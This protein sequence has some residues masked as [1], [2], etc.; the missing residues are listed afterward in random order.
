MNRVRSILR[1][2]ITVAATFVSGTI[3]CGA[4]VSAR[5][6]IAQTP[7][8]LTLEQAIDLALDSQPLIAIARSQLSSSKARLTETAS[9]YYPQLTPTL[10]YLY[11]RSSYRTG[12]LTSVSETD[13]TETAIGLRQ[14]VFDMG[15]REASVDAARSGVKASEASLS[16][17]RQSVILN[18]TVAFYEV[19]RSRELL[20][21]QQTSVE[22]ARTTLDATKA[23]AEAGTVRRIDTL[24][25]ESDYRNAMV[26]LGVA[27]NNVRLAEVG[28]RNAMGVSTS[29]R[30]T[31]ADVTPARPSSTPDD[32]PAS[33]YIRRAMEA[34][35]DL[36]RDLALLDADRASA[37]RARISAGPVIEADITGGY[38]FD[39][40]PGDNR[41]FIAS[42]S[43]PLFDGG[44]AQARVRA[45]RESVKQSEQQ[46]EI[47]RQD[48]H[49]AVEEAYL[50][51]EEARLRIA[52]AQSASEA[53]KANY[54]AASAGYQE[55]A[56]TVLDVITA[57]TQLV[58]A[59]TNLVQ[60]VYDYHTADARLQRAIGANDRANGRK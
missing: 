17:S 39:P 3:L 15:L 31:A 27:Q 14:K 23:Y 41:S 29:D 4:D 58:T 54:E 28:L 8:E 12:G 10:E 51:R 60:S 25:A 37:R 30:V 11:Q 49:L 2:G 48:I 45:A 35:P 32:H 16:N 5:E 55:G 9:T 21:V 59:E 44:A 52:A 57:R 40:D 33:E 7:K 53:A 43:F 22:R 56:Q 20:R 24:Q 50:I 26:Q 13:R 47:A 18:V 42:L 6:V 36:K 38:R 1:H 34:R 19:L 46:L